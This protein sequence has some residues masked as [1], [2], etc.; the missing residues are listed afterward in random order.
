MNNKLFAPKYL[1]NVDGWILFPK[2]VEYRRQLFP[3][4]VNHPAKCNLFMLQAI[5]DYLATPESI[6][7][8]PMAGTGSLM[9][10]ASKVKRVILIEL[11]QTFADNIKLHKAKFGENITVIQGN[12]REVLPMAS[13]VD[14]IVFSP[15]YGQTLN[16][17]N[18]DEL[19]A[20]TT[21]IDNYRS[22]DR[23]KTSGVADYSRHPDNIAKLSEF[24]QWIALQDVY[25]KCAATLKPG[26]S[27][28][29]ITK[30]HYKADKRVQWALMHHRRCIKAG[31][32][33][34]D[35]FKREAIGGY[36]GR[37][38]LSKG[39]K[40]ATDEDIMMFRKPS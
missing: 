2:D 19:E 13:V 33:P 10:A 39:I 9:A 14:L 1:R 25:N 3:E 36:F 34:S 17:G 30:D 7:L 15:P 28:V 27:M 38:M 22:W 12:C 5:V 24:W 35:W 20:D 40:Q 32:V 23:W 4:L 8:D 11:E 29:L 6:L 21:P 31:L 26:G 16:R 37:F 18:L